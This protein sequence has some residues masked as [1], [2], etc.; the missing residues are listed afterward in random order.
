MLSHNI[1]YD[2]ETDIFAFSQ[3]VQICL[4]INILFI[5]ILIPKLE[6]SFHSIYL[7]IYITMYSEADT[8]TDDWVLISESMSAR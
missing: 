1:L 7:L 2:L 8:N 5:Q 3:K 6:L 4:Q